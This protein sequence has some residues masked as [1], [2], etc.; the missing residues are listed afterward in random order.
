MD[1]GMSGNDK[2]TFALIASMPLSNVDKYDVILL[3]VVKLDSRF[4]NP[5]TC[6]VSSP[7]IE[8]I[9][10]SNP[11]IAIYYPSPANTFGEPCA[12]EG[13]QCVPLRGGHNASGAALSAL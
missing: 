13:P 4:R 7:C 10:K 5:D 11:H 2:S 8:E 9:F 12:V 3:G 6:E 1:T